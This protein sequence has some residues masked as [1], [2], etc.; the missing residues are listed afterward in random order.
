MALA[1]ASR[2]PLRGKQGGWAASSRARLV[3]SPKYK[4][5]ALKILHKQEK[6]YIQSCD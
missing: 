6:Q 5:L 2:S 4:R 3:R 1:R